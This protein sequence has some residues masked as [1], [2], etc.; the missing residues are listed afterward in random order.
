MLPGHEFWGQKAV[1]WA[2][3]CLTEPSSQHLRIVT[4]IRR[5]GLYLV[6]TRLP[7]QAQSNTTDAFIKRRNLQ[8][9]SHI[10]ENGT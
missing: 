8:T 1:L 3:L 2:K 10:S 9:A 4:V 6:L 5:R 7:G